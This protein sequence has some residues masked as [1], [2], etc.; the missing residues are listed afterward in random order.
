[1]QPLNVIADLTVEVDGAPIRVQGNGR[2]VVADVPS[3]GAAWKLF[4]SQRLAGRYTPMALN[5]L[6]AADVDVEVRVKG[7][8]VALA[9][10]SAQSGFV[11]KLLG[12][13]GA[14]VRVF[15]FLRSLFG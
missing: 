1:M 8:K 15:A 5:G 14:E 7:R 12:I 2:Q 6:Q 10:P 13:P 4:R 9:G 3:A 11:A